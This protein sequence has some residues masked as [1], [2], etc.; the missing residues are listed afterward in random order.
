[1]IGK[2]LGVT[3]LTQDEVDTVI[4]RASRVVSGPNMATM[5]RLTFHDCAGPDGCNGCINIDSDSNN[6]LADLIESLDK[7]YQNRGFA[8]TLSR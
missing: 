8:S 1:M 7:V 6:G 2:C 4:S 5:L 3:S